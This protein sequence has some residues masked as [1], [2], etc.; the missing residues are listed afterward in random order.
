[1]M[2][3]GSRAPRQCEMIARRGALTTQVHSVRNLYSFLEFHSI[4]TPPR[5]PLAANLTVYYQ[6]TFED[7]QQIVH[8]FR[9]NMLLLHSIANIT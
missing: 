1:M 6:P 7:H 9:S 5:F 3:G 4:L 2:Y 8:G